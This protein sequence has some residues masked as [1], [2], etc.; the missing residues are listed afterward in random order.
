MPGGLT[1]FTRCTFLAEALRELE[2]ELLAA[3]L[4]E[5]YEATHVRVALQA[6][7]TAALRHNLQLSGEIKPLPQPA[8]AAA[9]RA[10]AETAAR[11]CDGLE[12][13]LKSYESSSDSTRQKLHR[14][15]R[16]TPR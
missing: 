1:R 2:T 10:Y 9:D 13:V 12:A 4:R 11:L 15:W 8:E 3:G 16:E 5:S 7:E 6:I 14:L